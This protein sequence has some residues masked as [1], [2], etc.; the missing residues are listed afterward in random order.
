MSFRNTI[1]YITSHPLTRKKKWN[2]L[3]RFAKWQISSRLAPG[4]IVFEWVNGA[5]FL[6]K[7]GETGLTGNIYTGLHE[8][9]DMA[10]VLHYLREDD[11][12]VDVGAN[13]G[14]YSILAG[15]AVGCRGGG[16]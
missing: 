2:A 9:T 3:S 14:S 12:F 8:F 5:K 1:K 13:A 6:V 16:I 10:F 4:A 11:F 7:A 15:A